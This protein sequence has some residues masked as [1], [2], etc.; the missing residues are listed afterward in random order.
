[1][2]QTAHILHSLA[3]HIVDLPEKKFIFYCIFLYNIISPRDAK[4][5]R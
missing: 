1:M 5:A 4:K 3:T 2:D